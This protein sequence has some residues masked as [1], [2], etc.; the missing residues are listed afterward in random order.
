MIQLYIQLRRK[1]YKINMLINKDKERTDYIIQ[2]WMRYTNTILFLETWE[3]LYNSNFNSIE[4]DG[5][6]NE[7]GIN[8]IKEYF[9]FLK[10]QEKN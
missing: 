4:F 6:K 1:I 2:N 7:S 10:L 3:Y 5:F 9:N 8:D